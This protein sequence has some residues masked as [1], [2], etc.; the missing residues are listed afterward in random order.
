M[1][2]LV[3]HLDNYDYNTH[4]RVVVSLKLQKY[5]VSSINDEMMVLVG[6]LGHLVLILCLIGKREVGFLVPFR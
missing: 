2:P 6:V 4:Q 1:E 3:P 5:E